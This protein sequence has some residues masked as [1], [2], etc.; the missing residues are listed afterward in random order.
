MLGCFQDRLLLVTASLSSHR[1]GRRI[2]PKAAQAGSRGGVAGFHASQGGD[3]DHQPHFRAGSGRRVLAYEAQRQDGCAT[4]PSHE[5]WDSS[6]GVHEV[7]TWREAVRHLRVQRSVDAREAASGPGG[8][9]LYINYTWHKELLICIRCL[10][11][12]SSTCT[13]RKWMR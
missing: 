10:D 8:S 4:Q 7:P 2:P 13:P 12:P 6:A 9:H 3:S 5:V 11:V 1:P